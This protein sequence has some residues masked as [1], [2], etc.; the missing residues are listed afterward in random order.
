MRLGSLHRFP[1]P[2]WKHGAKLPGSHA[3]S[4]Y[5][6]WPS[7]PLRQCCYQ[8]G[9]KVLGPIAGPWHSCALLRLCSTWWLQRRRHPAPSKPYAEPLSCWPGWSLYSSRVWTAGLRSDL[10]LFLVLGRR[11][12]SFVGVNWTS[13]ALVGACPSAG[14]RCHLDAIL[15]HSP[16]QRSRCLGWIARRSIRERKRYESTLPTSG[17][18]SFWCY[19][20]PRALIRQM[21]SPTTFALWASQVAKC[22]RS[23]EITW[24]RQTTTHHVRESRTM[25]CWAHGCGGSFF[26]RR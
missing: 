22:T 5:V 21:S 11:F 13:S 3:M 2:F 10:L 24:N 14:T 17:D 16:G 4:W 12:E 19:R 20:M 15:V 1:L 23:A 26:H 8:C 9:A 7:R 18:V 6:V 25:A